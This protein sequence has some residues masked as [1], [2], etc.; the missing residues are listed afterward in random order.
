MYLRKTALAVAACLMVATAQAQTYTKITGANVD[1]YFD[2]DEFSDQHVA[3]S[4][5][6][7]VISSTRTTVINDYTASGSFIVV[8]H[9]GY[10]VS[11]FAQGTVSSVMTYQLGSNG[12]S[13]FAD[14]TVSSRASVDAGSFSNG[15]F[16][17]SQT[18]AAAYMDGSHA[19]RSKPFGGNGNPGTLAVGSNAMADVRTPAPSNYAYNN[20]P[21]YHANALYVDG[22]AILGG[23]G[24]LVNPLKLAFAFDTVAVSAVPEADTYA[25]LAAGLGLLGLVAR[26]RKQRQA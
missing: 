9:A 2:V 20:H 15:A 23:S 7:F 14:Y 25:M 8:P 24:F 22:D 18:N 6:S 26:R 19:Q 17:A 10:L 1:F 13:V 4:G 11:S 16:T 3:V 5:N 12:D 21:G